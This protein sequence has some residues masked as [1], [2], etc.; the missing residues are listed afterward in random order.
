M[1]F[2]EGALFP[3]LSVWNNVLY[4]VTR[5]RDGE[6]EAGQ[7]LRLVGLDAL[8]NRFP[9]ELSGG[10]QQLVALARALAPSPRIVLLDEPFASLD[11]SLRQRLRE[12]VRSILRTA[13]I[14]AVL[15][16]HDQD[17]ALSLADRVAVMQRGRILQVGNPA[18]VYDR[19]ASVE[20]AEFIGGGQLIDCTIARGRL[21]SA[22]GV[23]RTDAP[24]GAGR[25]LVR[26]EALCV[27]PAE[28][29]AGIPA[30]VVHGR[31]FGH[32]A[33]HE[34]V[35]AGGARLQ[36]RTLGPGDLEPGREL[37]VALTATEFRVFAKAA[38]TAHTAR[39]LD[40]LPRPQSVPKT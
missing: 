38:K 37:R 2:Q 12:E 13:R 35:L 39:L 25:L 26:P 10:Q 27:L 28:A 8:R 18:E 3:H 32:D 29:P 21:E 15:V 7:A 4:G 31:Y 19:P 5:H 30:R 9:D 24:D 34:V 14:T 23:L 33:L 36:A 6:R 22:V 1:V 17:E 16:T 20:V 11:A 40:E